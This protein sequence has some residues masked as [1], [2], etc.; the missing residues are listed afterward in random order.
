M[1]SNFKYIVAFIIGSLLVVFAIQ[2]VWINNLYKSI[3]LETEKQVAE[4]IKQANSY[5]LECRMDSL[6]RISDKK[7]TPD[8]TISINQSFG[9]DKEDEKKKTQKV[10][11]EKRRMNGQETIIYT[12]E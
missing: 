8:N 7:D 5:E 10:I 6:D 3:E 9:T 12:R 1:N 11:K 2:L 4:C